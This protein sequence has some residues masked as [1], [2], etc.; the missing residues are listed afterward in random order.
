MDRDQGWQE[1]AVIVKGHVYDRAQVHGL[2]KSRVKVLQD[3]LRPRNLISA[4]AGV[5]RACRRIVRCHQ[6]VVGIYD[7]NCDD[8]VFGITLVTI[9]Y[10][11]FQGAMPRSNHTRY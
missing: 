8:P 2:Y 5:Q 6:I 4:A 10:S 9:H 7:K 11:K 1:S 3:V